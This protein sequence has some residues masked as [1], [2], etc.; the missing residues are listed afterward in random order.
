MARLAGRQPDPSSLRALLDA[1]ISLGRPGREALAAGDL[2]AYGALL[3]RGD[4][5]LWDDLL[6]GTQAGA[7]S[8]V[9]RW[10]RNW[11]LANVDNDYCREVFM[12]VLGLVRQ[13]LSEGGSLRLERPSGDTGAADATVVH[14]ARPGRR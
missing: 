9:A 6:A 10:R 1:V 5:G 13:A 7:W 14:V 11:L 8:P 3:A 12:R 4:S 2:A